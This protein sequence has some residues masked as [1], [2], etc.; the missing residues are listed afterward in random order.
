MKSASCE[1]EEEKELKACA[2][3]QE[4]R[5]TTGEANITA[6]KFFT[7]CIGMERR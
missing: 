6:A 2:I 5:N 7:I 1:E 4:K 3:L